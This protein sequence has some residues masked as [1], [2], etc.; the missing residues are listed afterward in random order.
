MT[1]FNY[2]KKNRFSQVHVKK[3][4]DN[5]F[6]APSSC[7]P[8]GAMVFQMCCCVKERGVW[9]GWV[10]PDSLNSPIVNSAI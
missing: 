7:N 2:L 10:S 1:D 4:G 6:D 8:F 5:A 9:G 3:F